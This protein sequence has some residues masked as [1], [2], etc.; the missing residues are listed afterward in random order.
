MTILNSSHKQEYYL[1]MDGNKSLHTTY[2]LQTF[3]LIKLTTKANF[4]LRSNN[5]KLPRKGTS[6]K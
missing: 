4:P 3:F 2:G 5:S 1:Q 6:L